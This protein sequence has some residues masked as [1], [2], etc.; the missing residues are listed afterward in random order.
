VTLIPAA[1]AQ[2]T[3]IEHYVCYTSSRHQL[4]NSTLISLQ[5][6]SNWIIDTKYGYDARR[7]FSVNFGKSFEFDNSKI[8]STN[9]STIGIAVGAINGICINLDQ[10][11]EW[12][13]IYFSSKLQ[14][15]FSPRDKTD[16]FFYTWSELGICFCKSLFSGISLQGTWT[17]NKCYDINKGF[18]FGFSHGR[19]S[20]PV[21]VFDFFNDRKSV[22]AGIFYNITPQK[23][24][25]AQ[26]GK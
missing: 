22:T 2:K 17:G 6:H 10:E 21:Y 19:C 18:V 12:Y 13:K 16:N 14:Y 1:F 4:D 20:F 26:A 23:P 5:N 11:I 8:T 7:T 25:M 3:S 24:Q 9:V 15:F